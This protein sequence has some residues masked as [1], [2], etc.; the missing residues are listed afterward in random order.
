MM[1]GGRIIL[2]MKKF[3]ITLLILIFFLISCSSGSSN[4][5]NDASQTAD[6]PNTEGQVQNDQA[7]DLIFI[8]GAIYT[9][10]PSHPW[11]SAVAISDGRI[12]F[13][14]EDSEAEKFIGAESQV[15]DLAGRMLMPG[16][17]DA[18]LHA[19]EAGINEKLCFINV[20]VNISLFEALVR[21]CAANNPDSTWV[22][23]SGVPI[24]DLYNWDEAVIDV[25]DRAVPDRPVLILDDLGHAAI[26]NS[27]AMEAA[28][29]FDLS[30]NPGGGI[31]ERETG[32]LTGIVLEDGQHALRT[33]AGLA[34]PN[35]A[36][37][38]EDA[39]LQAMTI[40]AS[41]GIT[42]VSDAG[43]YWQLGHID[44]WLSLEAQDLLSVRAS[45]AL[46]VY[47]DGDIEAQIDKLS[48]LYTNDPNRLLHFNQAKI[49]VDGILDQGTSLL[50]S[51][52]NEDMGIEENRGFAYFSEEALN[53][54]ASELS[55]AGFQLHFHV[56]GDRGANWALNA[57]EAAQNANAEDL[58]HRL[59]HLYLVH[60]DDQ[61]RFANLGVIADLQMVG[62]SFDSGYLNDMRALIGN[63]LDYYLPFDALESKGVK[64]V[65]SSDWDADQL[66]PFAKIESLLRNSSL[67]NM[68]LE[69]AISLLT[70]N[71]AYLL[72]QD[73]LTGS[74]EVGKA[75][76]LIVLDR[77]IFEISEGQIS[78]TQVLLTLLNGKEVYRNSNFR[79]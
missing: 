74:I 79:E 23:G 66:S 21:R 41:N 8:N 55:A 14:G 71:P 15:V 13:V 10:N 77:N 45:N 56:T 25:L 42:S 63:R 6:G 47:A 60:P 43:G 20:V 52:Y 67:K 28:G 59:T 1:Y 9:V 26:A 16:F 33:A 49:Y 51:Q 72:H 37:D 39:L 35:Q 78:Q 34:N 5:E 73:E 38:N 70:I 62:S 22:L 19:L 75:A 4:I 65:V 50:F 48:T 27:L 53:T 32:A 11:A 54:Y 40:L 2:F 46:Y 17:Q 69:K 68:D 29:Y 44:A 64:I 7:A 18:H 61:Q 24:Y 76:D 3:P 58:R 12:I 36:A 57:I 31:L 30:G